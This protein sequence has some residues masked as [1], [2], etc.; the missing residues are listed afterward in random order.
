M[1]NSISGTPHQSIP[2][3]EIR[4]AVR[5]A[6]REDIGRG[7]VTSPLVASGR[8]RVRGR[9]LFKQPGILCGLPVAKEVFCQLDRSIRFRQRVK[10]GTPLKQG[11]IA[12]EVIGSARAVLAGERVALNFLQRFSG[13]ATLTRAFVRRARPHGVEILDTRK[14][15]PGLRSLEKYAVRVG[16]GRN[17][18]MGLDDAV[19]IKD[20]HWALLKD[21][22]T[23]PI[24]LARL[25]QKGFFC[26]AEAQ[27]VT[28]LDALMVLDLDALLLDNFSLKELR[29]SVALIRARRPR[30]KIE[31]SGG[32][33]LDT[34][35]AIART[36]VDWI[37]VGALTHS[38][39]AKDISLE[40]E[41]LR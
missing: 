40:I 21:G 37:S 38:A 20:N 27:K 8:D 25:R 28:D 14:T 12:A 13:I 31:A 3:P 19:L 24:A 36:G 23:L 11:R 30:L 35:E 9:F 32:V 18:R 39:P 22:R 41:P 5:R 7:D 6:L 26:E 15:T 4:E 1:A 34:V 17:H 2:F 16:G 10:E 33:T 29:T